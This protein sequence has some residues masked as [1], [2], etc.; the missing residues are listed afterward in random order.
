MTYIAEVAAYFQELYEEKFMKKIDEMK[1]HKLLYLAQREHYILH[2]SAW[3]EGDFY[4][5]R[6][7]PVSLTVRTMYKSGDFKGHILSKVE[8]EKNKDLIEDVFRRYA[9][10]SS[11]S[12]SSIT[13][14]EQSWIRAHKRGT[15]N[16]IHNED[17]EEDALRAKLRR[18]INNI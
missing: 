16:K 4:A 13:H 7:G 3:F 18:L 17:I 12:L 1:L 15:D 14:G 6:F 9:A 2:K 11:W 8:I 5:Q 10:K